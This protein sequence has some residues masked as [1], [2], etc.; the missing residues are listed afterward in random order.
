MGS[1][2]LLK[3]L[4]PVTYS[5]THHSSECFPVATIPEG[6]WGAHTETD[7]RMVTQLVHNPPEVTYTSH[8]VID[9]PL[10]YS[11]ARI[12]DKRDHTNYGAP[13]MPSFYQ[14]CKSILHHDKM[15]PTCYYHSHFA[16]KIDMNCLCPMHI[17]PE[18]CIVKMCWWD[19]Q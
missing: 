14:S 12:L 17:V 4:I 6:V 18:Q 15:F 16:L 13:V 2:E 19:Y 1:V 3:G 11:H 5:L 7:T 8:Y 10:T 9:P